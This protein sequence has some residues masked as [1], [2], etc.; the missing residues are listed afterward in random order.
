MSDPSATSVVAGEAA[1]PAIWDNRRM[2]T[3]SRPIVVR[4]G[5]VV[6]GTGAPGRVADIAIARGVITEVGPGLDTTGAEV[7][8][9]DG[10]VV[11]P[12]FVDIH[13]HFDGQATWDP[14]LAPS[15]LHG[16]TSV[17]MGNCGVGFA[18]AKPT[19]EQHDWLIGMLEGVEDIP[20]TALAEGLPWDWE[21][22]PDYLD[23]LARRHYAVDVGTHVVHAPL[24]AYVMGER[25]AN[26]NE[27]PTADELRAMA[28]AVQDGVRAGALGFTTS[29]TVAH[30]TRDGA[31]LGTRHSTADELLALVGAM[32]ETG[33]GVVQMISDAYLS[34]D[35]E[36]ALDEMALMRAMVEHSRRPLS[37]TVQQV[38]QVPDRWREMVAWVARCV[39]DGLDMRTQ[40]APRPVGVLQGLTASVNPVA[41]CPSYREIAG[42]PLPE[43]VAALKDPQRRARIVAEH[44]S[45]TGSLEGLAHTVFTGFDKL[46]PMEEPVDYE[47]PAS[48]SV[49]AR[50]AARGVSPV[51]ETIDLMVDADGHQLL[52]LTLFNYAKGNLDDVREMLLSPNSV[53]GLGDAGAHCGAISDASFPTTS[54]ALWTKRT[55]GQGPLPL[56]LMVHHLTQRTTRQVGWLDRGVLAAGFRADVNV[57]DLDAL[58]ANRPRIVHDLP[59]GGRRLM[60][61]AQGY[62]RTI[63]SG[64]VTF[65]DGAHT[66]ALPGRLVRGAQPAPS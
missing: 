41:L 62:V 8:D 25:G 50:A 42:L 56:E 32:A 23:A 6:D 44:P 40:V 29:R 16:V 48:S 53:I 58:G 17:A 37:M 5:L 2:S 52:I 22:F 39:A 7:I 20:G 33:S 21:T 59:A 60:Q 65:A 9:A 36:F 19:P 10:L 15:S 51:E 12:G 13:T 66:G 45:A 46:F 38:V 31:P 43:R 4:N 14:M 55:T 18:P 11:T 63:K 64:T 24:R 27:A 26:P 49:A 30:R 28:R 61:S 1:V 3:D 34:E 35:D 47:P 57:I 54:L